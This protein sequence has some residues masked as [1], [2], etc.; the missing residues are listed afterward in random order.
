[1]SNSSFHMKFIRKIL[2]RIFFS[3]SDFKKY[4]EVIVKSELFDAK[5]YIENYLNEEV[6]SSRSFTK[7]DAIDHYLIKGVK[8]GYDPS[9]YFS[10]S[11]YLN[12]YEDVRES[13]MNP[14]IHFVLCGEQEGRLPRPPLLEQIEQLRLDD[15]QFNFTFYSTRTDGLGE[16]LKSLL[17]AIVLADYFNC[18]FKFTW[19]KSS[20]LGSA[21]SIASPEDTFSEDFLQAYMV[22]DVPNNIVNIE[23]EEDV[24]TLGSKNAA[25]RVSQAN[26]VQQYPSLNS[27]LESGVFAQAFKTI[28]FSREINTA[29][30]FANQIKIPSSCVSIHL[31]SGDIVYGRYRYDDRHTSKVVS[32]AQA[33]YMMHRLA[34][35][36]VKVI[37]FGQ[38]DSVCRFLANKFSGLFFGDDKRV[39][40]MSSL[41]RAI[42]DM[43]LMSRTCKIYAGNSGFSQLAEL[44]GDANISVPEEDFNHESMAK[45]IIDILAQTECSDIDHYQRAFGCWHL[46]YHFKNVIGLEQAIYH[47]EKALE[48]TADCLFYRVVLATMYHEAQDFEKAGIELKIVLESKGQNTNGLG[49]YRYLSKF[50]YSDGRS[51]LHNYRDHLLQMSKSG[52]DGA[53]ALFRATL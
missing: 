3:A 40:G 50:R 29:I 31:R 46:V 28:Q 30:E 15:S 9:N 1:M 35:H 23:S 5:F 51:P 33:D 19:A 18:G 52:I 47:V 16:R 8:A 10:T 22:M 12:R 32:F 7:E 17:N 48:Y 37:L 14:L 13:G 24:G 53:E 44:I 27:K 6:G 2:P 41:Q 11:W 43:V 42:F 20:Y 34:G 26:L 21:H 45:H 39:A 25:V 49:D 4:R 36:N 38:S